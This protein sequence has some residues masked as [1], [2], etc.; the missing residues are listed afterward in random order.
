[1][2]WWANNSSD[3]H[4]NP[5][6]SQGKGVKPHRIPRRLYGYGLLPVMSWLMLRDRMDW[7]AV[8]TR[9]VWVR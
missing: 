5:P 4:P 9:N 7:T 1:M 3:P 2:W 6:P 8:V